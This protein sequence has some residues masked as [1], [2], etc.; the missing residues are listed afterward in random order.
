MLLAPALLLTAAASATANHVAGSG[1]LEVVAL[2]G[3]PG[4]FSNLAPGDRTEWGIQITNSTHDTVP[5]YVTFGTAGQDVL[6]TDVQ[7]GLQLDVQLC[8]QPL[9]TATRDNGAVVFACPTEPVEICTAAAAELRTLKTSTGLEAGATVG[10]RV[11]VELPVTAGN[12]FELTDGQLRA[13]FATTG[14]PTPCPNQ[15][16]PGP[17]PETPETPDGS[18]SPQPGPPTPTPATPGNSPTPHPGAGW[19]DPGPTGV[20]DAPA[21]DGPVGSGTHTGNGPG[22]A[23]GHDATGGGPGESLAQTGRNLLAAALGAIAAMALGAILLGVAR[24]T[25]AQDSP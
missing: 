8:R 22:A 23:A 5:L 16:T 19:P 4:H 11:R 13:R 20:T 2:P 17:T 3:A 10:L 24:R 15:P 18:A 9:D 1:G 25:R 14:T 21:A 7:D 12:D 6:I